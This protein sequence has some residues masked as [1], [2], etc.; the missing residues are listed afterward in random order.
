MDPSVTSQSFADEGQELLIEDPMGPRDSERVVNSANGSGNGSPRDAEFLPTPSRSPPLTSD[1]VHHPHTFHSGHPLQQSKLSHLLTD[2]DPHSA[3]NDAQQPQFAPQQAH[4]PYQGQPAYPSYQPYGLTNLPPQ[5]YRPPLHS[6]YV[7]YPYARGPPSNQLQHHSSGPPPPPPLLSA[8]SGYSPH[9]QSVPSSRSGTPT[10]QNPNSRHPGSLQAQQMQA[11]QQ[12]QQQMIQNSRYGFPPIGSRTQH[13]GG[14]IDM[15]LPPLSLPPPPSEH[16]WPPSSTSLNPYNREGPPQM[17]PSSSSLLSV[18]NGGGATKRDRAEF[19]DDFEGGDDDDG[20]NVEEDDDWR[21]DGRTVNGTAKGKGA[22]GASKRAKKPKVVVAPDLELDDSAGGN[23]GAA[24]G[25][26][27]PVKKFT[28]PHASCGRA[29]AR[30][31]NLQSHIK[32]HMGVRDCNTEKLASRTAVVVVDLRDLHP[33]RLCSSVPQQRTPS[34]SPSSSQLDSRRRAILLQGQS[35]LFS[36]AWTLLRYFMAFNSQSRVSSSR[37]PFISGGRASSIR[38]LLTDAVKRSFLSA[39]YR[40]FNI[41]HPTGTILA[42]PQHHLVTPLDLASL[43]VAELKRTWIACDRVKSVLQQGSRFENLTWRLGHMERNRRANSWRSTETAE[44]NGDVKGKGRAVDGPDEVPRPPSAPRLD[45]S[46][47]SSEAQSQG[48]QP[49]QS[50]S[51][52]PPPPLP[53]DWTQNH[54]QLHHPQPQA[55]PPVASSSAW[56]T[57]FMDH[58]ASQ[59]P[60]SIPAFSPPAFPTSNSFDTLFSPQ[61][62]PQPLSMFHSSYGAYAP[63]TGPLARFLTPSPGPSLLGNFEDLQDGLA[64]FRRED[65]AASESRQDVDGREDQSYESI[66]NDFRQREELSGEGGTE[67]PFA[68]MTI[69][70]R[71][72]ATSPVPDVRSESDASQFGRGAGGERERYEMDLESLA[73]RMNGETQ[74]ESLERMAARVDGAGTTAFEESMRP[75]GFS[76]TPANYPRPTHQHHPQFGT[77]FSL[78]NQPPVGMHFL[79]HAA[80]YNSYP[81]SIGGSTE[82][83]NYASAPSLISG[84]GHPTS[85]GLPSDFESPL[86]SGSTKNPSTAKKSL[87]GVPTSQPLPSKKNRNPHATQLPGSGARKLPKVEAEAGHEGPSCSHCQSIA[88]PLWRRGPD[89]E[90]LCNACGL[91]QKLHSKP[92]PRA[93]GKQ[94][95]K[96]RSS[97]GAAAQAAASLTPPMCNNCSATST[98]MWRRDAEGKLACNACSLYFKLHNVLRP[99]AL[100]RK[101]AAAS[102]AAAARPSAT[103][104]QPRTTATFARLPEQPQAIP[105]VPP[106]GGLS[107]NASNDRS[108]A[109]LDGHTFPVKRQRIQGE[110]AAQQLSSAAD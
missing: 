68:G 102:A 101:R 105:L 3:Q 26:K 19:D 16:P 27:Q 72:G 95:S 66:W 2:H 88:T 73:R 94:G 28:C 108:P 96:A 43:D 38:W 64:D 58:L 107:S 91:Y 55:P 40:L 48:P 25:V 23:G 103:P 50:Y 4:Y 56:G 74:L 71:S 60:P 14:G 20:D 1:I 29:F 69:A 8:P 37:V 81:S 51:Y 65:I 104:S 79:D 7:P 98:P 34:S 11:Q 42:T 75:N 17:G 89:D 9:P 36:P 31:F 99:I 39:S 49:R 76:S 84:T 106:E 82:R 33:G 22:G 86:P 44:Y 80:S 52:P 53:F 90:L 35:P 62:E 61:P 10:N 5:H 85:N 70:G 57:L 110:W 100:S 92:R 24:T 54:P 15:S 87:N 77:D 46:L 109:A 45:W 32:S 13:P 97:S 6:S 59:L 67:D 63:V 30:N 47:M 21:D 78:P 93:F 12:Q 18:S 83:S 41:H